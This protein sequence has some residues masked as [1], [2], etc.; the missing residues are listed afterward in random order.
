M[1]PETAI[2]SYDESLRPRGFIYLPVETMGTELDRARF[3]RPGKPDST[4]NQ[5]PD[6]VQ[7]SSY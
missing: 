1:N 6:Y 4:H 5:S 3:S 7:E 2:A